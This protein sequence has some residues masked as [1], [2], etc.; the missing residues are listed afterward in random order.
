MALQTRIYVLENSRLAVNLPLSFKVVEVSREYA[1]EFYL[2]F[3]RLLK[4]RAS[5]DLLWRKM[6]S[7]YF[8]NSSEGRGGEEGEPLEMH[9]ALR[10]AGGVYDWGNCWRLYGFMGLKCSRSWGSVQQGEKG[11]MSIC[12]RG[13]AVLVRAV[14]HG[15]WWALVSANEGKLSLEKSMFS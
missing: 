8:A 7:N 10:T 9:V 14:I 5:L 13:A 2:L 1:Q 4:Y 12:V 15:E 11:K 6:L 3:T